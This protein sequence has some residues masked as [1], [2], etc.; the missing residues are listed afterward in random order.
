MEYDYEQLEKQMLSL[1]R[2]IQ[3][4]L[5]SPEVARTIREIGERHGLKIDQQ[6]TM[7]DIAG[8]AMLGLVPSANFIEVLSKEAGI[9]S[10][11]ARDIAID[12]NQEVF[13][14]LK[15]AIRTEQDREETISS[16][17]RAGGFSVE[18]NTAAVDN[19]TAD[20][21]KSPMKGTEREK[22]QILNS[23]ENPVPSPEQAFKKAISEDEG[24][25]VDPIAD[26]LLNKPN[27]R[28]IEQIEHKTA[29]PPANVPTSE[30]QPKKAEG[31]DP[32][33]EPA[34]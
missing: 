9:P 2:E 16:I 5:T 23:I 19:Q 4:A 8:Y 15:L 12:L 32:Y 11:L 27:A 1:P 17:E 25:H 14:R 29:E 3:L 24:P 6:G 30:A 33:R 34:S 22:R 20:N 26:L 10:A 18:E 31:P 13:E 21:A 28:P 7:H